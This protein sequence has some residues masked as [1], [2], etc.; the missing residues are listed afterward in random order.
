MFLQQQWLQSAIVVVLLHASILLI[1]LVCPAFSVNGYV[2]HVVNVKKPL[3]YRLN[4]LACL[5][6]SVSIFFFIHHY[7]SKESG[8]SVVLFLSRNYMAGAVMSNILGLIVSFYLVYIRFPSL[9]KVERKA[10]AFRRAPTTTLAT[11]KDEKTTTPTN[12]GDLDDRSPD[13]YWG[14]EFTP[15]YDYIG[16]TVVLDIKMFLYV[17]GAILLELNILSGLLLE[18]YNRG[19]SSLAM[20][21]YT[22]LLTWFI[23]EY[24][25]FER[26][27]LY[28]YD[29]FAEKVG[30][31]LAWGCL[32]FYPFFYAIGMVPMVLFSPDTAATDISPTQAARIILFF[33]S[34]WMLTRGANLQKYFFRRFPEQTSVFFGLVKQETLPS[35]NNRILC[36]GFWGMARHVNY[37]GEILQGLALALPGCLMGAPAADYGT[38]VIRLLP[39]LYPIYYTLLFIYRQIDDDALMRRR[40][41]DEVMDEYVKRVPYRMVPGLY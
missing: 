2:C 4:G 16:G 28:T 35:S 20:M 8:E 12:S 39:L 11:N 18:R 7:Y 29:L 15:R 23:C 5:V 9:P 34:G 40:Y 25:Y 38:L 26:I 31:K 36:A 21:T 27:H 41:G 17:T 6:I 22:G 30:F 13:F 14:R 37:L 19:T 3:T 24:L 1:H 10:N 33:Y 32:C